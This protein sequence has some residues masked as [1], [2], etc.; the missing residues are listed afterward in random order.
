MTQEMR[1]NG[2]GELGG[3]AGFFA[4][5]GDA[6]AGDRLGDAVARKEPG[7]QLIP[8]DMASTALEHLLHCQLPP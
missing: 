8:S 6:I 2:L 4:D 5:Q 7:L 3:V 1:I